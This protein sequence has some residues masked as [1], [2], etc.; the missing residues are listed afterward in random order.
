MSNLIDGIIGQTDSKFLNDL[1][2]YKRILTQRN[3][4]LKMN[5]EKRTL[6]VGVLDIYDDKLINTG[7][8]IHKK[9]N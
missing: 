5:Y 7:N 2:I 6:D 9:R 4:L 8:R 1:I 3:A